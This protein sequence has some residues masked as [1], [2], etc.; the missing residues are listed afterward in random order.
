MKNAKSHARLRRL[1]QFILAISVVAL[2]AVA[3]FIGD[4]I[5]M[6]GTREFLLP[7]YSFAMALISLL[8]LIGSCWLPI[9]S[10]PCLI[11]VCWT[12]VIVE[13]SNYSPHRMKGDVVKS[14]KG[15]AA[16]WIND[17]EWFENWGAAHPRYGSSLLPGVTART[18]YR[19]FEVDYTIGSD[20]WRINP[21]ENVDPKA[22]ELAFVGCS[23]TFG[24]G[25]KDDETYVN[26]LQRE[27]WPTWRIRNLSCSGW[28]TTHAYLVIEDILASQPML[29]GVIY[30]YIEHHLRRN[31]LRADYW[32]G[33]LATFPHFEFHDGKAYDCGLT[34]SK[35][36]TLPNSD[37][38]S[39]LEDDL[40]IAL[41]K[42]I[43]QKCREKSVPFA[44]LVLQSESGRVIEEL[45][46]E[47][48]INIVDVRG[49]S[50]YLYLRDGHPTKYWHRHVAAELSKC[51][52]FRAIFDLPASTAVAPCAVDAF[53][54][55]LN[56]SPNGCAAVQKRDGN[57]TR[58]E[59]IRLGINEI[60]AVQLQ[61]KYF[62]FEKGKKYEIEFAVRSDKPRLMQLSINRGSPTYAQLGLFE[63]INADSTWKSYRFTFAA[64]DTVD[65][66]CIQFNIGGSDIPVEIKD[67][68]LSL[69]GSEIEVNHE[70]IEVTREQLP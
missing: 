26:I 11:I 30:S 25:V 13:L 14:T 23:F 29:K 18:H 53:P 67:C 40:T 60:W 4:H 8:L 21:G 35:F 33:G 27:A 45:R 52:D 68:R 63:K 5:R 38:V 1:F 20:G 7:E 37:E 69:N 56:I 3:Y 34:T 41:L 61:Q 19:E 6:F 9:Q 50:D 58:A 15:A 17:E 36:A 62:S 32:K 12:A 57:W 48:A 24:A 2:F 44:V 66:G 59:D 22:P 46:K 43:A 28:G 65:D 42:Q 64:N 39:H 55:D 16:T 31:Y 47:R 51:A 54:F 10:L 49:V 70:G